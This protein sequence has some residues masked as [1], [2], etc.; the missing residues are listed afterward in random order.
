MLIVISESD[1]RSQEATI[2]NELFQVGL[3]LFHIRKY[4]ASEK[5]ISEWIAQIKPE[6]QEKLV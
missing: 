6:Y 3:D 5:E 4:E 2:V 1:F